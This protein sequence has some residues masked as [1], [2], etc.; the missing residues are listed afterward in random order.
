[1]YALSCHA[2]IAD[3]PPSDSSVIL[4][5]LNTMLSEKYHIGHVTI[6]FECDPHQETYCAI[7]GLYCHME[8]MENGNH[9][10]AERPVVSLDKEKRIAAE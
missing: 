4:H 8:T 1:M 6:Q 2:L 3:L 5:S 7:N 10:H 9:K